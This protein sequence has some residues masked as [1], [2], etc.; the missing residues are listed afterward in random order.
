MGLRAMEVVC[1]YDLRIRDF[2]NKQHNL[3]LDAHK[4]KKI[5]S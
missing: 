4:H 5:A 3:G 2:R 1:L